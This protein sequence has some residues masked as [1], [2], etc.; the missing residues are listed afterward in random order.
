[1]GKFL[2]TYD[3]NSPGQK[4]KEFSELIVKLFPKHINYWET[5]YLI[6]TN[7]NAKEI[8]IHLKH[9]LDNN[10]CVLVSEVTGQFNGWFTDK[11]RNEINSFFKS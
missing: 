3:L 9:L 5:S 2:I 8:M 1:M 11:E 4:H 7:L 10:D 6:D